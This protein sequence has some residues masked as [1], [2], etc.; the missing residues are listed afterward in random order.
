MSQTLAY[1]RG[2][3]LTRHHISYQLYLQNS[4]EIRVALL[5]YLIS[6]E[7]AE[8]CEREGLSIPAEQTE[9]TLQTLR[10]SGRLDALLEKTDRTLEELRE[11]LRRDAL[12]QL[13]LDTEH[14]IN[15][16]DFETFY[17]E[18][19]RGRRIPEL[20][21]LRHI[22]VMLDPALGERDRARVHG[23]MDEVESSPLSFEERVLRYSEC[24]SASSGG[25]LGWVNPNDLYP[26]IAHLVREL[27]PGQE[28][29]RVDTEI[30]THLVELLERR[31][32][33]SLTE[34]ESRKAARKKYNDLK[35]R[36]E[37]RHRMEQI[38]KQLEM[39]GE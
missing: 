34:E 18:R 28:P 23:V 35:N 11:E 8:R 32:E 2:E 6:R 21:H 24:P 5:Q 30:G 39:V 17:Q 15:E 4:G 33:R 14:E 29:R 13:W 22:L 26:E 38:K 9:G 27:V 37:L 19:F 31:E 25:D 7:V 10:E 16:E 36:T 1:Y 20:V 12:L 3:P